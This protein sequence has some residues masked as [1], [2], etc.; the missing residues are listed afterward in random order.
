MGIS[1]L[2]ENQFTVLELEARLVV[3]QGLPAG[4]LVPKPSDVPPVPPQSCQG[5]EVGP[6]LVVYHLEDLRIY[7]VQF[8]LLLLFQADDERLGVCLA[9]V[10]PL[11]PGRVQLGEKA[12]VEP[13]AE[14]QVSLQLFLCLL[15]RVQAEPVAEHPPR[16]TVPP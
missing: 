6:E 7:L 2:R 5:A 15:R 1:P 13:E 12:V 11:L 16:L 4:A 8:R 14:L 3:I 10:H 9:E